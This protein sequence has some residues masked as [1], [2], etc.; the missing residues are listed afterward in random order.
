L[1]FLQKLFKKKRGV[2]LLA[3]SKSTFF[4]N[5]FKNFN[6]RNGKNQKCCPNLI[7]YALP[8][9]FS[10]PPLGGKQSNPFAFSPF[11][12]KATPFFPPHL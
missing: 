10:Y 8:V 6:K 5:A 4:Y 9:P 3:F 7:N 11:P 2:Y 12:C 1:P